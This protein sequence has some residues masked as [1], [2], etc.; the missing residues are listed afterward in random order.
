[1]EAVTRAHT[2]YT[3]FNVVIRGTLIRVRDE[4]WAEN[5]SDRR[6]LRGTLHRLY[7]I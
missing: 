4:A 6:I 1:M 2:Q 5:F 7:E 3:G